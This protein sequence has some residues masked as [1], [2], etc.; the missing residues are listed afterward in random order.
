MSPG[1]DSGTRAWKTDI[2]I[3]DF[4][5]GGGVK[6]HAGPLSV[7]EESDD[8]GSHAP[9]DVKGVGVGTQAAQGLPVQ[10]EHLRR[11]GGFID[12]H[13]EVFGDHST[14]FASQSFH[15]T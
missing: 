2:L 11:H 7:A 15:W 9:E 5:G 6:A 8:A 12:E 14:P 10:A 3:E 4:S 13:D 1:R